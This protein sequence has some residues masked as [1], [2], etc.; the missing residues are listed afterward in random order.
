M[1]WLVAPWARGLFP[2]LFNRNWTLYSMIPRTCRFMQSK[3]KSPELLFQ[4][5]NST[6]VPTFWQSRIPVRLYFYT[7]VQTSNRR[8]IQWRR[9]ASIDQPAGLTA[10]QSL[11]IITNERV[12]PCSCALN[13]DINSTR[14][15]SNGKYGHNSQ[16][17]VCKIWAGKI[18]STDKFVRL[19]R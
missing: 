18:N 4:N 11:C 14:S 16:H 2:S 13:D 9:K 7:H 17:Q 8:Q 12:R 19:V 15:K 3:C 10:N 5:E 6:T 1:G